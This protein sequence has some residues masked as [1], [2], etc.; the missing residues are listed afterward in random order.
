MSHMHIPTVLRMQMERPQVVRVS[1]FCR[2]RGAR[3][4][5]TLSS[6]G[7]EGRKR[8][9]ADRSAGTCSGGFP[10][11]SNRPFHAL[12]PSGCCRNRGTRSGA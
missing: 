5:P 4:D 11:T 3:A 2:F 8:V 1:P 7:A 12:G 10:N 9:C 6:R